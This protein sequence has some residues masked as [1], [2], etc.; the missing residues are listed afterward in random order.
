MPLKQGQSANLT[1]LSSPSKPASKLIL[2]KNEQMIIKESSLMIS[3]EL[4]ANTN[5]NLTK[6]VYNIREPDSSWHN[7]RLRC[8]QIYPYASDV[9]RDVSTRILVHCESF[10]HCYSVVSMRCVHRFR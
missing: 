7:A 4:D 10:H 2:Y 5:K 1:C 3:Y 6:L 8:E 9:H